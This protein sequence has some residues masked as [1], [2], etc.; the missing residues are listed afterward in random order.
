MGGW[1]APGAIMFVFFG[2]RVTAPWP[3][4]LELLA[5]GVGGL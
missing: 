5:A 2:L 1:V 3:P 4:T